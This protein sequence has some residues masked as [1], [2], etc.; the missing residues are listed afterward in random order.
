MQG[1]SGTDVDFEINKARMLGSKTV[2]RCGRKSTDPG[3]RKAKFQFPVTENSVGWGM[4]GDNSN[5]S[6]SA[7]IVPL[8]TQ[9]THPGLLLITQ[10]Q[11]L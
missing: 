5:G 10:Q 3:L 11:L 8:I 1:A 9:T 4:L 6:L 7:L 2:C